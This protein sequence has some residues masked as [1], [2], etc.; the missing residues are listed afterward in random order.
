MKL[1]VGITSE[2][3]QAQQVKYPWKIIQ[4]LLRDNDFAMKETI[5]EV[6]N[7]LATI[8]K[9]QRG[10]VLISIILGNHTNKHFQGYEILKQTPSIAMVQSIFTVKAPY[11]CQ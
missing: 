11:K 3:L 1:E 10:Q 2:C 7:Y 9:G 4:K 8:L 5:T 6:I